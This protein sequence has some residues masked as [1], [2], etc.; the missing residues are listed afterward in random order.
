MIIDKNGKMATN[1]GTP[2]VQFSTPEEYADWKASLP[3]TIDEE[4]FFVI[5]SYLPEIGSYLQADSL[6]ALNGL[7]AEMKREGVLYGVTEE[8]TLYHYDTLLK[9]FVPFN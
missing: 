1:I 4:D 8:R 2:V 5:L 3:S 7:A 9:E 6:E